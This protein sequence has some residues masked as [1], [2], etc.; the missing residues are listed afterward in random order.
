MLAHHAEVLAGG[1]KG[2]R[3]YRDYY[4]GHPERGT[5][6]GGG[7][8]GALGLD[9]EFVESLLTPTTWATAWVGLSAPAPG[10]LQIAPTL[11]PGLSSIGVR[12]ALYRGNRL[13][14]RASKG[15]VDLTGSDIARPSAGRLRLRFAGRHLAD[16]AVLRDGKPV[17]GTVSRSSDGLVFETAL[18][19]GRFTVGKRAARPTSR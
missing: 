2:K 17:A 3:F 6:Q 5:L 4:E 12:D 7:P 11:P 13:S 18:A 19:A 16:A 1:G 14:I 9:E 8:Q 15:A 10:I